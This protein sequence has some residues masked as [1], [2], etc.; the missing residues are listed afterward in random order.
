MTPQDAARILRPLWIAFEVAD[1][2]IAAL[3]A[4]SEA[5][6]LSR[7]NAAERLRHEAELEEARAFLR[8]RARA[9]DGFGLLEAL[10][11]GRT[12]LTWPNVRPEAEAR[13]QVLERWRASRKVPPEAL[14]VS[15]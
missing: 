2:T 5:Q 10:S 12:V 4:E 6:P 1:E 15:A 11:T 9:F 8:A 3:L 13:E 7:G 14:K